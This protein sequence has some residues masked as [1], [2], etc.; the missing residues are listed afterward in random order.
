MIYHYLRCQTIMNSIFDKYR[1]ASNRSLVSITS[2]GLGLL[3]EVLWIRTINTYEIAQ[4]LHTVNVLCYSK[5]SNTELKS[6]ANRF[7]TH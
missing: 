6:A 5:L 4:T 7:L 1:K 2:Q 3:L